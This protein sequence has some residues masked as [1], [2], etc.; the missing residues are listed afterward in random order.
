[1]QSGGMTLHRNQGLQGPG[2]HPAVANKN[3]PVDITVS[4]DALQDRL[5]GMTGTQ[6]NDAGILHEPVMRK[7]FLNGN[8]QVM[9]MGFNTVGHVHVPSQQKE[10]RWPLPAHGG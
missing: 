4:P 3:K 5:H 2:M 8:A 1:M 7:Q 9:I 10:A 6:I